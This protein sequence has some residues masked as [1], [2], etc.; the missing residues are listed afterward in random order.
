MDPVLGAIEH[1]IA[2]PD[3]QKAATS[4]IAGISG[5]IATSSGSQLWR[6]FRGT[7]ESRAL[8]GIVSAALVRAL[9][10]ARRPGVSVD[11]QWWRAVGDVLSDIFTDD[12]VRELLITMEAAAISARSL[13]ARERF[14]RSMQ[15][16]FQAA[17]RDLSQLNDTIDVPLFIDLLPSLLRDEFIREA[18]ADNSAIRPLV[19]LSLLQQISEGVNISQLPPLPPRQLRAD[20]DVFLRRLQIGAQRQRLPA[21]LPPTANISRLSR[22]MRV[23]FGIRQSQYGN[24]DEASVYQSASERG[25]DARRS[26][27]WP[28]AYASYRRLVLVGDPGMG[29]SWLIRTETNRL[30]SIAL[31]ELSAGGAPGELSIPIPLRCDEFAAGSEGALALS[32]ADLISI[33]YQISPSMKGWLISQLNSGRGILLLDALDELPDISARNQLMLMLEEWVGKG[34]E[35]R[36]VLTSRIAGYSGSPSLPGRPQDVEILPFTREDTEAIVRAW[37]LPSDSE[38]RLRRRLRDPAIAGMASIPL[39]LALLCGLATEDEAL[40]D[41]RADLYERILRRFLAHEHRPPAAEPTDVDRLLQVLAPTAAS[42]AN[43]PGGWQDLMPSERLAAALRSSGPAF[44]E[45][46]KDAYTVIRELSVQDGILV[47][48]G[49]QAEGRNPPYLFLHRSIAEF[50]VAYHYAHQPTNIWMSI[51]E[52]HLWFDP[53]WQEV[54]PLL[55]AKILDPKPLLE[56]LLNTYNDPLHHALMVAS[57]ACAELP[58]S[59]TEELSDEISAIA[60]RLLE[61]LHTPD[62]AIRQL[63]RSHLIIVGRRMPSAAIDLLFER[64]TSDDKSGGREVIAAALA[65]RP[66]EELTNKILYRLKTDTNSSVRRALAK[67]LAARLGEDVTNALI[68]RLQEDEDPGVREAVVVGLSGH[69]N[70]D[71]T[72][73]LL[74]AL[75]DRTPIVRRAAT[76]ALGDRPGERVTS[77]LLDQLEN[78]SPSVQRA[79]APALAARPGDEVTSGLLSRL[80]NDPSF[81]VR[82]AAVGA[83]ANRPGNSI[84][85]GLLDRLVHDPDADVR[86][87][88]TRALAYRINDDLTTQLLDRSADEDAPVRS[89]AIRALASAPG[90]HVTE[91]LLDRLIHDRNPRVRESAARSLADRPGEKVTSA[92]LSRL[93]R[94][95]NLRA[96]EGAVHAL[97]GR[98]GD[99]VTTALRARLR[100]DSSQIRVTA[101]HSLA[102]RPGNLVTRSLIRRLRHDRNARVRDE[103]ARALAGRLGED[104]TTALLDRVIHDENP[105]VRFGAAAA[106]GSAA[107]QSAA[108]LRLSRLMSIL[109]EQPLPLLLEPVNRLAMTAYNILEPMLKES[110]LQVLSEMTRRASVDHNHDTLQPGIGDTGPRYRRRH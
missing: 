25:L 109:S 10:E 86:E 54:L 85:A 50:L 87:A 27:T 2:S 84:T 79:A 38:T 16:A 1:I 96:R 33:R 43:H 32:V 66:G 58:E 49:S 35:T 75:N 64:L 13:E 57:R 95:R 77:A 81:R 107:D 70:N 15:V 103:A 7:D 42:F 56:F 62:A 24:A 88:A 40:P 46:G 60:H 53:S 78:G 29:K 101:A 31:A 44:V 100:L 4:A 90:E 17:E 104:V 97:A 12:V 110:V 61:L 71:A 76:R 20:V 36:F 69:A 5:K 8:Q 6:R 21:Y 72:T 105:Q 52:T 89:A 48:A 28:E 83:L 39:L 11:A 23:R 108:A 98:S 19:E 47:P 3:L 37:E 41:T 82:L 55:G 30:A 63:A 99:G 26:V 22:Q 74:R 73:A 34:P 9:E 14:A 68:E 59:I 102:D 67:A 18:Y 80:V 106:L 94:E 91:V 51:V 45:L 65:A 93:D 92:L